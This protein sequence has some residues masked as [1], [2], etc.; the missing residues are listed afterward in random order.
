M[1]VM[2]ISMELYLGDHKDN[3]NF[4]VNFNVNVKNYFFYLF[5]DKLGWNN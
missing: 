1:I 2:N 3:V 5:I 4:N